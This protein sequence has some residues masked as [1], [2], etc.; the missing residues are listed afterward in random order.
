MSEEIRIMLLII[1]ISKKRCDCG[2]KMYIRSNKQQNSN[3]RKLI[4]DASDKFEGFLSVY[5]G[6]GEDKSDFCHGYVSKY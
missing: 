4:S 5:G 2:T 1:K 6:G 3:Y